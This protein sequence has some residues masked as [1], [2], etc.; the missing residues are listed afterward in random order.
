MVVSALHEGRVDG[1]RKLRQDWKFSAVQK[2][3]RR[4]R[5]TQTTDTDNRH[6]RRAHDTAT[7][8]VEAETE[9]T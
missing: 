4:Y 7:Q 9:Q 6:K 8:S 3:V 2:K 5:Q 1:A